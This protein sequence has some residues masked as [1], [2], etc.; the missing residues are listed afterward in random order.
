MNRFNTIAMKF[1]PLFITLLLA[2]PY[3]HG[4]NN[5]LSKADAYFSEGNL[6][7][8]IPL[9]HQVLQ[10]QD[11][12]HAKVNLAEA[13]YGIGDF[14]T[15]ANWFALVMPLKE[16]QPV[17][18][19]KYGY[20]LLHSG[21]CEAAITW[22]KVYLEQRPFDPRKPEL[23]EACNKRQMLENKSRGQVDIINLP[24]NTPFNEF[25]PVLY[26]DGLVFTSDRYQANDQRLAHLFRVKKIAG[27]SLSFSSPEN[28]TVET[29]HQLHEG[30]ATFNNSGDEI[31]YTRT[32]PESQARKKLEIRTGRLLP[33]GT[34]GALY[35]LTFCSDDYAVA[36][37]ALSPE[38]DRL[39]FASDMPGGYGGIDLYVSVRINGAWGQPINL[40]PVINTPGDELYPY[41]SPDGDLYFSSNGLLGLGMQDIFVTREGK[42]GAWQRPENLGA[43]FNSPADDF[44]YTCHEGAESGF[45]TSN[46]QGGAGGDDIYY[47]RYSG[48]VAVIDVLDLT[49]GM[50]LPNA[51]V[52]DEQRRDTFMTDDNG[53]IF[54][55]VPSCTTITGWKDDY[56]PKAVDICPD[57]VPSNSDTLF[58][59]IALQP[60]VPQLLKGVVFD[61]TSGHPLAGAKVRL[62][63]EGSCKPLPAAHTNNQGRFTVEMQH[64]CCYEVTAE[65]ADFEH[66]SGKQTVCATDINGEQYINLFLQP[67]SKAV[68]VSVPADS[69]N[70][71]DAPEE[72]ISPDI[73]EDFERSAPS[74]GDT[75]TAKTY[76]LN[77][78]YD[79]GRSSVQPGSVSELLKLRDLLLRNPNL[80][81]EI[82]SHTDS[83]G[84]APANEEL[85]QR[86][87]NAIVR[88]LTSEGIDVSRMIPVGY[89]EA[90]LT[91]E[92]T[93]DVECPDWKHQEN[94]RTEF[95]VLKQ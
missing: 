85:S 11:I 72:N 16:C 4:Q 19:L 81:V 31:F 54:L 75:S 39:F 20:A 43:P 32:R 68:P 38:G 12:P 60:D 13:Y 28:F 55:R 82:S 44:G 76:K 40:G 1:W 84:D 88:Y 29:S 94:R 30:P 3:M 87:A 95:R 5:R 15:A 17:H 26:R 51:N 8:A 45:L 86:R 77:V 42:D 83:N 33:Q 21:K 22:F 71:E 63:T 66:V 50:P 46:R 69:M 79:T 70:Q 18:Q 47:F 74:A 14:H 61:R 62:K 80:V 59:A 57:D 65:L 37:P 6:Q 52:L 56:F 73:F 2:L 41:V 53:R 49:N 48:R 78:Y 24:F 23:L 27:D 35:P 64:E 89:G 58:L 7:A 36:F 10:R 67:L 34:W 93:D 9:Y 25:S 91:N 92:C 90:L